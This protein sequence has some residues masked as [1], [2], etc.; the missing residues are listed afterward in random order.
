MDLTTNCCP[1]RVDKSAS[2]AVISAVRWGDD[3]VRSNFQWMR[4]KLARIARI[5][6]VLTVFVSDNVYV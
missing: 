4:L 3:A 6:T 2:Y 1:H 5:A